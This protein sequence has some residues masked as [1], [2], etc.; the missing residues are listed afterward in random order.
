MKK[1]FIT[2]AMLLFSMEYSSAGIF[3]GKDDSLKAESHYLEWD[4]SIKV[5][6]SEKASVYNLFYASPNKGRIKVSIYDA[7]GAWIHSSYFNAAEENSLKRSFNLGSLPYGTYRF[8]V[9]DQ[10]KKTSEIL[11]HLEKGIKLDVSVAKTSEKGKYNLN[12][13]RDNGN[14]VYINIFDEK[15]NIIYRDT[16]EIEANFS[17]I[18]DLSKISAREFSFEVS[19]AGAKVYQTIH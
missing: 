1:Q 16:I 2:V 10:G 14:P 7:S 11:H 9:V 15:N 13:L 18:Y 5:L 12:V 8:E 4:N 19:C 6:P 17:R 3:S